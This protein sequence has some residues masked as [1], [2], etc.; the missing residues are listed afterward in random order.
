MAWEMAWQRKFVTGDSNDIDI[1]D[2]STY[3]FTAYMRG[4]LGSATPIEYP[5][6]S[7]DFSNWDDDPVTLNA[8]SLWLGSAL[9]L[10]L[11]TLF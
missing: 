2:Q 5:S 9:A 1:D 4:L 3:E 7:V 10:S 6:M 11:F 8:R